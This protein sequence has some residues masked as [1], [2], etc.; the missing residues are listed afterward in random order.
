MSRLVN[1]KGLRFGR[2]V[3]INKVP[4]TAPTST[5]RKTT[6]WYCRCSCGKVVIVNSYSLR[7]GFTR[8]CGCLRRTANIKRCTTH[9]LSHTSEYFTWSNIRN[10]CNNSNDTEYQLYGG[11]GIRVCNR[12]RSFANFYADMGPKPGPEYSIDRKD[13]N[14]GYSPTNCRWA[15]QKTQ[16]NNRRNNVRVEFR[17][18]LLT[19]S[20]IH[21]I[22]R[23][24]IRLN[25]F[26]AR[27]RKGW[28]VERALV[29]P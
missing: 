29:W 12:W 25:T 10:R 3:V 7:R 18:R 15:T 2:L 19:T 22:S 8:S 14:K 26:R 27:I 5:S 4:V 11:R 28:E 6:R 17:G 24:K 16:Q 23:S 9:G 13:S 20:Q 1:I 21:K